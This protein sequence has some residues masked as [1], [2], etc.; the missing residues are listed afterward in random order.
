MPTL[1]NEFH[2]RYCQSRGIRESREDA[3]L[4]C[5][6]RGNPENAP[7][8]G[9]L[10]EKRN[11]TVRDRIMELQDQ[12]D[13]M[14]STARNYDKQWVLDRLKEQIERCMQIREVKDKKGNP[15]GV[16][17]WEAQA[18]NKAIE[19]AGR[20]LGMFATTNRNLRGEIDPLEGKSPDQLRELVLGAALKLGLQESN[21]SRSREDSTGST[22]LP[23][24]S[25]RSIPEAT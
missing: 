24:S 11:Y 14:R 20:E 16:F 18:A 19:L 5:G 25:V 6:L 8:L 17:K 15:K 7:K 4:Q 12:N 3:Y 9:Y 23:A 10:L 1:K 22:E 2:E 21:T 13:K